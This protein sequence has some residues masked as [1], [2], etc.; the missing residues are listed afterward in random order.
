MKSILLHAEDDE[1]MEAR[2][3]AALDLARTHDSHITCLQAVNYE[4]YAPGD[5]YGSAM[6]AV[7]PQIK[8][9]AENFRERIENDLSNEDVQWEWQLHSGMATSKLLQHSALNDLI[10]V[11]PRDV[12]QKVSAPSSMIA[13]LTLNASIPVLVVPGNHDRFDSEAP[14]IVAWNN[15]SEACAALRAAVPLL[16]RASK[17]FLASVSEKADR[18]R[19]DF[20]PVEGA[21]YLSRH[22]IHAEILDIPRDGAKVADALF[23]AAKS[24]ACGM[25]VMGAYGHSRLSEFLLGGVTRRSLADPQIPIML[26]H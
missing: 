5:F 17:V 13:E 8:K 16:Q 1:C 23:S 2:L 26:A 24:H 20:P 3:Q 10:V 11:G 4:L 6:S 22:G 14:V 21:Q 19:F 9:A 12:G 25:M 15:S 18:Q 7:F